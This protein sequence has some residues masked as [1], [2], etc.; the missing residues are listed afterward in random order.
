MANSF[1]KIE[2]DALALIGNIE[3]KISGLNSTISELNK[4]VVTLL[5]SGGDSSNLVKNV[6]SVESSMQSMAKT[7]EK[8]RIA[9]SKLN[10]VRKEAT[11]E[12][13]SK[14]PNLR[15]LANLRKQEQKQL[16]R[17]SGL[18]NKV[19]NG[20]RKARLEY[21][22]LALRKKLDGKLNNE[23]LKQLGQLEAKIKKYD[24]AIK[25]V[26]SSMGNN[27][28]S[29][30]NYGKAFDSLGFSVA[31]ITRESPAFL[32]S[33]N[34]GFMAISNNIPILVDEINKLKVANV[35]LAKDGK[36]TVS[37]LKQLGAAIFSWQS[38]ISAGIVLLTLFG[39]K[40][41]EF[42]A[43]LFGADDALGRMVENT[44]KL[45]EESAKIASDS[46]PQFLGLVKVVN[47][48]STSEKE[49]KSAMDELKSSYPEF[50]AQILNEKEN[51]D[52]VSNAID[53]YID[54]LKE[55]AKAQAAMS[56]T[57]EKYNNL[58]LQEQ[59]TQ[60]I[61]DRIL[62]VAQAQNENIKT[63]EEAIALYQEISDKIESNQNQRSKAVNS[64]KT[65]LESLTESE[66]KEAD[67]L[68]EINQ[69]L[70]IYVDNVNLSSSSNNNGTKASREKTEALILEA[71]GV[72]SVVYE[73]EKQ[74]EAMKK[75]KKLYAEGS[76]EANFYAQE[77]AKI[78]VAM[79]KIS[80]LDQKF[81]DAF[82]IGELGAEGIKGAQEWAS[83]FNSSTNNAT[84][85]SKDNWKDYFQAIT[86]LARS[87][88]DIINQLNETS[89]QNELNRLEKQKDIAIKLAGDSAEAKIAVE[90]QYDRKKAAIQRKQAKNEKLQ[91]IFSIL[92]NTAQA[93]VAALPNVGLSIAAGTIGA[94]QLAIASAIPIPE[95]YKGTMN[96]PEG[97]ALVDERR[98]EI[99]TDK[100]GNIKSFGEGKANYR[101][102]SKGDKIYKSREEYFNKELASMLGKNDITSYS[103][104]FDVGTPTVN[105]S[106]GLK[107][108][109]F[110]R[111]IRGLRS[112]IMSKESSV[113]NI[114]KNGFHTSVSKGGVKR[115]KQNNILRLK[116]G[117]V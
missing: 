4:N 35:Q 109:D 98:P 85:K 76:R 29:V 3:T 72:D 96:A 77:I 40:I 59:N 26:D 93:V 108:H 117:I 15:Q 83:N 100:K 110:V 104:M 14:I 20:L 84:S 12:I 112:D 107:K 19:N 47:D 49:R 58:I 51:T 114:D 41:V 50:N 25:Q 78:E 24:S 67:I 69:L 18:Y 8:T 30:G 5:N 43:K 11:R 2:Q 105:V 74:I 60:N 94:A 57:Q 79:G 52:L 13:K 101:Y 36:P 38:L 44:A 99:H 7:A 1:K 22:D 34:T 33:L 63:E 97:L 6:K 46:I 66:E 103:Q 113:I 28:R 10:N 71:R 111:E 31:Q 56:L 21:R 37:I 75:I 116:K 91:T 9:E 48:L 90:E 95:F 68:D 55:K 106:S 53:D 16:Q 115:N 61:K 65:T 23:Q 27:Q 88:F 89:I 80:A 87:T 70:D 62:E 42:T 32:N 39:S 81:R 54:V 45:N 73:L 17:T 82:N 92:L 86:S 64:Y 102:L